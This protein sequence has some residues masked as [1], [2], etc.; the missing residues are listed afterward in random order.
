MKKN[1][2]DCQNWTK[3]NAKSNLAVRRIFFN[4]I[5]SSG[6]HVVLLLINYIAGHF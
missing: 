4:L 1:S 2:E 5:I 6:Q 3:P